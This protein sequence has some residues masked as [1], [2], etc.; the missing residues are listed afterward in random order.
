MTVQGVRSK[1][2]VVRLEPFCAETPV[3]P[4]ERPPPGAVGAVRRPEKSR[5]QAALAGFGPAAAAADSNR[6]ETRLDTPDSSWVTP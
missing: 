3:A 5:F 1:E 6:T 4:A 2:R